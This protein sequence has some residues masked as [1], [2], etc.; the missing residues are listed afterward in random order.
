MNTF[1]ICIQQGSDLNLSLNLTDSLSNPINLSGYNIS[2]FMRY[3]YGSYGIL[4]N[5]NP[6]ITN[7]PSGIINLFVSG[8]QI[9][10]GIPVTVGVYD[11]F[12]SNGNS[13]Q[14][15]LGGRTYIDPI[16]SY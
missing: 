14:K 7:A 11:I 4:L 10:T 2:G 8:S 16:V 15:V 12:I 5:L 13:T 1:N 6:T 3:N 9:G